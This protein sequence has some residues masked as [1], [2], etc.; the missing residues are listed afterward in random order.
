MRIFLLLLALTFG[1]IDLI[2]QPG[3]QTM[4][5]DIIYMKNGRQLKGEILVFEEE[6][7]DITFRDTEGRVYS[8]TRYQYDYFV[9][10][11]ILVIEAQDSIV[12]NPR[13]VNEAEISLGLVAGYISLSQT[14]TEGGRCLDNTVDYA[15]L[16]VNFKLS[17]GRYFNRQHFVGFTAD[18]ALLGDVKT[19]FNG[20]LRYL[21]QYPAY[22]SNIAFY[23]PIEVQYGI[24]NTTLN[25]STTDTTF[26]DGGFSWPTYKDYETSLQ[27]VGLHVG[28]GVAF[29]LPDKRSVKVE[30]TFVK[31]FIL[32]EKILNLEDA[33]LNASFNQVGVRLGVL[34]SL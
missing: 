13:K 12:I 7:G 20:G 31:N 16:P 4:V 9:E 10:D 23:L 21:F 30:L 1:G 34:F 11:R 32:N 15:F 8:I 26:S 18:L 2:A 22:K 3:P 5:I 17:V 28:Q 24:L 33:E 25:Y 6:D 29:I 14:V 27:S 19:Y